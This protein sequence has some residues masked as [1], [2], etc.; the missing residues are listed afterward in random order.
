MTQSRV[1]KAPSSTKV[2]RAKLDL[3]Q[4]DFAALMGVSVRTVQDWEQKRRKPQ[5]SA[6]SLLRI[7]EQHPDVFMKVA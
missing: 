6:K 4:S 5:G 1:L 7:A 3:S 2:I